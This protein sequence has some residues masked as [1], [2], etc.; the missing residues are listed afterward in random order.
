MSA[1]IDALFFRTFFYSKNIVP[2]SVGKPSSKSESS[3]SKLYAR[4]RWIVPL[5]RASLIENREYRA[6]MRYSIKLSAIVLALSLIPLSLAACA[7]SS[8]ASARGP[9]KAVVT[10]MARKIIRA[11]AVDP[12]QSLER[13]A[14]KKVT[15]KR[16]VFGSVKCMQV[17]GSTAK[18]CTAKA[19]INDVATDK[20]T[21]YVTW[22]FR[23]AFVKGKWTQVRR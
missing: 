11:Q 17:K 14:G 5:I 7:G 12:V 20:V 13:Q 3:S 16:V 15:K 2:P 10:A 1:P 19:T 4:T 8:T 21:Q 22:T 23:V 18:K 9:T 6:R